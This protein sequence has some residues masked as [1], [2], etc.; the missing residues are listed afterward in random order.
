MNEMSYCV[1]AFHA[2]TVN[3]NG[4]VKTCCMAEDSVPNKTVEDHSIIELFNHKHFK[5]IRDDLNRGIKNNNCKKCWEEEDAGRKS[6]RLRDNEILKF[7]SNDGL[8]IL[9]LNLGNSCN[10]KCRTCGPWNSNQWIQE[11]YDT[12]TQFK[13]FAVYKEQFKKYRNSFE[14]HSLFWKSMD[15]ALP[16]ITQIDFYGGEPFL[17]KNQW[18]IVKQAVQND[19][20]KNIKIHYNTNGTIWDDEQIELLSNFRI[21]DIAI[22]IDGIDNRFEYMRHMAK[23]SIVNAN[24]HKAAEWAK[25]NSNV[26]LTLCY[27]ISPLNVWYIPEILKYSKEMG[28]SVYLNLVHFPFYYNI[29]NIPEDIKPLI[30]K[31]ILDYC[32]QHDEYNYWIDGIITFMEQKTCDIKIWNEF[33]KQTKIHDE[34]RN[35]SYKDTFP[36]FYEV[37]KEYL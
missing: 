36:E 10:I 8:K 2:L 25:K 34:Y 33:C 22:S 26:V 18:N 11:S 15:D 37:I 29:Q 9:D 14:D 21:A 27:T 6:K 13:T 1:N 28:I 30:K 24:I 35:E 23:W 7:N 16:N 4:R 20:A 32:L 3:T 17:I 19:Y 31:H 12:T 5:K